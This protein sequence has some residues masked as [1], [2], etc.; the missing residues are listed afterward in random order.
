MFNKNRTKLHLCGIILTF[1]LV[2]ITYCQTEKSDSS[3]IKIFDDAYSIVMSDDEST[4]AVLNGDNYIEVFTLEPLK[5]I[6]TVKVSR[7]A[8]LD[9]AFFEEN[10]KKLYYDKGVWA[11]TKYRMIDIETGTKAKIDCL[12]VPSVLITK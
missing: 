10:N 12:D 11:K 6:L 9:K 3:F 8:W 4:F 2:N 5:K 7:N 1:F